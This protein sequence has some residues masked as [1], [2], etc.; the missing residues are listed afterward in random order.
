[1]LK[2]VDLKFK[3]RFL[4]KIATKAPNKHNIQI[5]KNIEPS[6]FAQTPV[7]LYIKGFKVWE[8]AATNSIEKSDKMKPLIK[9]T[10]AK[11]INI[12]CD[13]AVRSAENIHLE[14]L[15]LT[16]KSGTILWINENNIDN[17]KAKKPNST[18]M[19]NPTFFDY[20]N[21]IQ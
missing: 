3:G 4:P 11:E 17:I 21:Q 5:H 13:I 2:T 18:N 16:P 1:M 14:E 8:L 6:W 20:S 10:K 7:I 12:N 9:M 19:Y 15:Y